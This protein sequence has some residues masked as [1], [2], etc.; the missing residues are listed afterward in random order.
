MIK[1]TPILVLGRQVIL[2]HTHLKLLASMLVLVWFC[3]C[4]SHSSNEAEHCNDLAYYYHYRNLDSVNTYAHRA[5][6]VAGHDEKI[7]SEAL[8]HL[9]FVAI[10]RMNYPLAKQLCDSISAIS[11]DQIE[12]LVSDIQQMRICQRESRNKDFY[13]SYQQ[14]GQRLRRITEESNELTPRQQRRMVYARSEY[15]IVAS[16]YF[17]YVGLDRQAVQAISRI[18]EEQISSDTAQLINYLYSY[19]AGGMTNKGTKGEVNQQEFDLL[20]RAYRLSEESQSTFWIANTLQAISEHLLQRPDGSRL[21]DDNPRDIRLLNVDSMPDSLLAGN[22]A[23]RS[24]RLFQRYG[25]VYQTAGALRTLA[26]CYWQISDYPSALICLQKALAE[27]SVI[28]RAPDLVASIREQ[29]C[30]VY[31]AL[32]D[33]QASDYNRNLYLDLQEQTRQDRFYEARADQLD[34][35]SHT[36]NVMLSSVAFM[37]LVLLGLLGLFAY[38]RNREGNHATLAPLLISLQ[39][40]KEKQNEQQHNLSNLYE[41]TAEQLAVS[42]TRV[43]ANKRQYLE[44]RA[45]VSL[46]NGL[47]PLIDRMLLEIKHLVEDKENSAL[48]KERMEYLTELIHQV[49]FS[50][51][52]LTEW[53][54]LRQGKPSVQIESFPIQSIFNLIEK[55]KTE[56]RLKGVLLHIEPSTA[57][58]KADRVLTLFMVNTLIDN[59]LKYTAEKGKVTVSAQKKENY[60]EVSI[61]DTGCGMNEEQL[62][63]LFEFKPVTDEQVFGNAVPRQFH[64]HGFGLMNCKGIINQ[65]RKISRVFSVC[66]LSVESEVSKGSRFFFR[67]P[68]GKVAKMLVLLT[69]F[70]NGLKV[71]AKPLTTTQHR[72]LQQASLFADSAYQSNIRGT[73][74]QTLRYAD[75]CCAV[76]NRFHQTLC[77]DHSFMSITA[78]GKLEIPEVKWLRERIPV[79]YDVILSIRNEVAVAALALHE[80][81]IYQYNNQAYTQLFKATS[82][83]KTLPNYCAMMQRS[84]TNKHIAIV[85]LVIL[86]LMIVPS[87]YFIYYRHRISFLLCADQVRQ[88]TETLS[89]EIPLEDKLK[90]AKAVERATLPSLL[91]S[92]VEQICTALKATA[93]VERISQDRLQEV[94]EQLERSKIED[95]RLH[96]SNSTLDNSLSALKHETM[97]YPSRIA[98][99]LEE[100]GETNLHDIQEL[101]SYYRALFNLFCIQTVNQLSLVPL[102]GRVVALNDVVPSETKVVSFKGSKPTDGREECVIGDVEM[103]RYLFEILQKQNNDN[104]LSIEIECKGKDYLLLRIPIERLCGNIHGRNSLFTPSMDNLPYLLC[105]QIVRD[106]GELTNRRGCGIV[107]QR[108]ND[109]TY[110][111]ITLAKWKNSK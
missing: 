25:D 111:V 6:R 66:I 28:N 71:A 46:V 45:K 52:M 69:V 4:G 26:N 41:E 73:Y 60:V 105:S 24:L 57:W 10:M 53:I 89:S 12:L 85:L 59:A 109:K 39:R 35:T 38:L 47:L 87:Y 98:L 94:K 58:V 76:L 108:K 40:W 1:L 101:A 49:N 17:Y 36:L 100:D 30:I 64:S 14:A 104:P 31:S 43:I 3:G 65:Y 95:E 107:A 51:A 77:G 103:L 18:G 55:A 13:V 34:R 5:I 78:H 15:D 11:D 99:L 72:L 29:L 2:R 33:K 32:D 16:T 106:D 96:L 22:L 74:R 23:E 44:Q 56:F 37:I 63:H 48:R 70:V 92:L 67:L 80:W 7:V 62:Q 90:A 75:S 84:E 21:I 20:M 9:A 19:G 83:D 97:Y 81:K 61:A 86:L 91:K 102:S 68:A 54:K 79:N 82:F 8:N 110:L 27:D 88:L 42:Q 50:N 93:D